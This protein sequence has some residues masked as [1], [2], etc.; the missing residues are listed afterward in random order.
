MRGEEL[1]E[2]GLEK[3]F[4]KRYNPIPYNLMKGGTQ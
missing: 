2:E 4:S 1:E 3:N